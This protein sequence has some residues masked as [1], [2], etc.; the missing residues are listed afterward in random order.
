MYLGHLFCTQNVICICSSPLC[1]S[2]PSFRHLLLVV[3]L[4]RSPIVALLW[5]LLI[6]L[7]RRLRS[8]T[9]SF[10][11]GSFVDEFRDDQRRDTPDYMP[12]MLAC[13]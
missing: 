10:P 11:I 13:D 8:R 4:H 3:Q 7:S 5:L 1:A 12:G 6:L 2:V 9:S